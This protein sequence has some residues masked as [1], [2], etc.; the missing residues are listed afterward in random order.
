MLAIASPRMT[1]STMSTRRRAKRSGRWP[2]TRPLTMTGP[3]Y[4]ATRSPIEPEL[5]PSSS[6]SQT[7]AL[8]DRA[9]LSRVRAAAMTPN[10][11][12]GGE[13]GQVVLPGRDPLER[14]SDPQADPM[15]VDGFTGGRPE[16]AGEGGRGRPPPPR[17]ATPGGAPRRRPGRVRG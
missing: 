7:R 4:A 17:P 10:P 3:V 5:P 11:E 14:C 6:S 8:Q 15:L 9:A 12:T 13:P 2:A 1:L 16:D